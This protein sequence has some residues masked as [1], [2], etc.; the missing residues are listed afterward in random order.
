M[1]SFS[2]NFSYH[3]HGD[4]SPFEIIQLLSTYCALIIELDTKDVGKNNIAIGLVDY[5]ASVSCPP[6]PYYLHLRYLASR[7]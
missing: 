2:L 5:L 6:V 1:L 7:P 3:I 4:H